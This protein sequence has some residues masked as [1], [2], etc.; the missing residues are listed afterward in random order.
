MVKKTIRVITALVCLCMTVS[1]P[2]AALG[3]E[4][5][6]SVHITGTYTQSEARTML[7]MINK[8]RADENEAW[9]WNE[10]STDKVYPGNKEPLK[11]DYGLEQIAKQ[12]AA[13]IAL[14]FGH[15]RP[16]GESCFTAAD[17]SGNFADGENIAAG[18][19]AVFSSASA[20]FTAWQEKD[21]KY[22]G[23]GH[24]RN[25]LAAFKSVGIAGFRANGCYYWVQ[26]FGWDEPD[27]V[28]DKGA[29]NSGR[30]VTVEILPSRVKRSTVT[31]PNE[32]SLPLGQSTSLPQIA[33]SIG[34]D[35][36]F[37]ATCMCAADVA[38]EAGGD[39]VSVSGKTVTA[40][41]IGS[42]T[43]KASFLGHSITCTVRVIC[44][45]HSWTDWSNTKAATCTVDGQDSRHCTVCG[46]TETRPVKAAGHKFGEAVVI[47][48]AT[49]TEDGLSRR[50]C[51]VCGFEEDTIIPRLSG[52]T[53]GAEPGNVS[54]AGSELPGGE[55]SDV[56]VSSDNS[57]EPENGSPSVV[58]RPRARRAA[59]VTVSVA[60]GGAAVAAAVFVIR[61]IKI[62][63]K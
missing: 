3:A 38:W 49:E 30:S 12:R 54:A 39:A 25:M 50:K 53:P 42:A 4:A 23:Q 2:I 24:R 41:K 18:T 16:D 31:P 58:G 56:P 32:I 8:F 36:S 10:D 1:A 26:E 33:V 27:A 43:L 46:V 14:S 59:A 21:Q 13:E 29:D 15:T 5:A 20:V 37:P 57:G 48:E 44:K 55:N 61:G 35:E 7:E 51:S 28:A 11:Y 52:G 40:R 63:K 45:N 34:T 19:G 9:Y 22:D 62:K 6:V 17:E 47:K 60:A